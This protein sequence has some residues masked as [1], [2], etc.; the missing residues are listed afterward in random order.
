MVK[1]ISVFLGNHKGRLAEVTSLLAEQGVNL[2]ALSIADTT[3]FGILRMVVADPEAALSVL[4]GNGFTANLTEL[5]ALAVPHRPGGLAKVMDILS[6]GDV[7]VEYAY[8]ANRTH[9]GYAVVL[10]RVDDPSKALALLEAE[11]ILV[12]SQEQVAALG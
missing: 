2:L 6:R 9:E 8:S 10:C 4:K 7:S 12:L 11:N 3:N 1:Q 5:V